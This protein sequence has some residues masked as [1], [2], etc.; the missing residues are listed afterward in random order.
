M[1]VVGGVDGWRAI[2]HGDG[3]GWRWSSM[4]VLVGDDGHRDGSGDDGDWRW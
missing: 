1:A 4:V 2:V 3:G